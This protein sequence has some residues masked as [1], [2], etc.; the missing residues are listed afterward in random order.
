ML[1]YSPSRIMTVPLFRLSLRWY[2]YEAGGVDRDLQS[3]RS[4]QNISLPTWRSSEH[5][6][7]DD[8]M[9]ERED[10]LWSLQVLD[11]Y[12]GTGIVEAR[13]LSFPGH[14]P[15]FPGLQHLYMEE[16]RRTT[17]LLQ[18]EIISLNDCLYRN[19]YRWADTSTIRS[20]STL[21]STLGKDPF[22]SSP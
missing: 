2:Q 16:R 8:R 12:S 14:L 13:P 5:R 9:W 22:D 6:E 18:F 21:L 19:M 7:G 17:Q 4:R 1:K 20:I 15:N 11:Y 10:D 3:S